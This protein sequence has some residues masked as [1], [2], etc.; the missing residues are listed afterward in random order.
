MRLNRL[1]LVLTILA[2]AVLLWAARERQLRQARRLNAELAEQAEAARAQAEQ[3]RA[4]HTAL[5]Q[6]LASQH[7]A[8]ADTVARAGALAREL[9]LNDPD[10][11]WSSPPVQLPDWNPDSPYV[12]L[13]KELL[14]RFP[15]Q[16]FAPNGSLN[17]AVAGV[18]TLE[19]ETIR[20]L[21]QA[22]S[23]QLAEYRAQEAARATPVEEH[24]PN[25][26]AKDGDKFTL[27]VD[28]QPELSAQHRRQFENT[29]RETLGPQRADIVLQT[30]Q[31]WLTEQFGWSEDSEGRSAPEPKIFSVAR[32]PDGHYDIA[33]KTGGSWMSVGGPNS[34]TDYIPEH[35]RHFFLG[36]ED[37]AKA[38]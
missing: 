11:L 5:K 31:S 20:K 34:L 17:P 22:L 28:P 33:I 4:G 30:A 35:L 3:I 6:E 2:V 23:R 16:P 7:A 18:L 27:R 24:L 36:Q 19:P 8:H 21:N 10:A 12:W 37:Q 14:R 29:L 32:H 1:S 15:V 13:P 38:P 25:I 26:A 9:G